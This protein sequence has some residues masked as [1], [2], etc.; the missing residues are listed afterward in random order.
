MALR[1]TNN[2]KTSKFCKFC[3]SAGKSHSEYTNH[4]PKD[5]PGPKGKVICPTIL[6]TECSYCHGVGHAKNHCPK[7]KTRKTCHKHHTPRNPNK[8]T[9]YYA[10]GNDGYYAPKKREKRVKFKPNK[11]QM[12]FQ[13]R[14]EMLM[15]AD[16]VKPTTQPPQLP[17]PVIQHAKKAAGSWAQSLPSIVKEEKS[18]TKARESVI[19]ANQEHRIAPTTK[20]IVSTARD[21]VVDGDYKKALEE[22]CKTHEKKP[23]VMWGDMSSDSEWS[24][25]DC[26]E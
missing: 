21:N 15:E 8:Q 22:L 24:D 26:D 5:Q 23:M 11:K 18:F 25:S 3:K 1:R 14:Y 9:A 4:Y 2:T 6:S 16:V 17:V 12:A 19:T 20:R 13:N 7:L 10:R